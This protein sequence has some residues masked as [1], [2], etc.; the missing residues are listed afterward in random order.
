MDTD[1]GKIRRAKTAHASCAL[2]EFPCH[3]LC[4][5]G[6]FHCAVKPHISKPQMRTK[7]LSVLDW[8]RLGSREISIHSWNSVF[9]LWT[10]P[11]SVN[12]FHRMSYPKP[13]EIEREG[14]LR[15]PY[16]PSG[17]TLWLYSKTSL[18][19]LVPEFF[20]YEHYKPWNTGGFRR[21]VYSLKSTSCG[22]CQGRNGVTCVNKTRRY[23]G[24][25]LL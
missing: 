17:C 11:P 5:A 13:R 19:W 16:T 21:G 1:N 7:T 22:S 14:P 2:M 8:G 6:C 18:M 9:Q 25:S 15:N 24:R 10:I 20:L 4:K 12:F 23:S 3:Y